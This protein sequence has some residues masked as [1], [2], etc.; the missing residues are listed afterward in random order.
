[1]TRRITDADVKSALEDV[2][3]HGEA[4]GIEGA[5]YWCVEN[6]YGPTGLHLLERHHDDGHWVKQ[7]TALGYWS[8]ETKREAWHTLRVMANALHAARKAT[9]SGDRHSGIRQAGNPA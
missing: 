6:P 1:M 3:A 4:L 8:F 9:E 5:E 2:K 7:S